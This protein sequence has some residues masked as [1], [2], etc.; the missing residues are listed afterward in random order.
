MSVPRPIQSKFSTDDLTTPVT[1]DLVIG[2]DTGPGYNWRLRGVL[3]KAVSN[4]T[5]TVTITVLRNTS[6]AVFIYLLDSTALSGAQTVIFTPTGFIALKKG[7]TVRVAITS[8]TAAVNGST[9]IDV[10]QVD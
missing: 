5:E 2:T 1:V 10:Q 7:D 9:T 3:F 4:I 6:A 8:A